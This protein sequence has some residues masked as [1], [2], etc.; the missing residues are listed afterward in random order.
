MLAEAEIDLVRTKSYI[1]IIL[2]I[3][4]LGSSKS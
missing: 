4:A 2:S 3:E 1:L